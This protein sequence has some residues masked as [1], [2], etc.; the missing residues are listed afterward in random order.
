MDKR[1]ALRLAKGNDPFPAKLDPRLLFR[2]KQYM[3]S[4]ARVQA[5]DQRAHD[6][7]ESGVELGGGGALFAFVTFERQIGKASQTRSHHGGST[8]QP[9]AAILTPPANSRF[10]VDE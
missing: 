1:N 6:A 8:S 7:A 3:A 10:I 4:W 5:F 9:G 2:T